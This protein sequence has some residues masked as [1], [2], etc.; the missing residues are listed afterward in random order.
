MID[1]DCLALKHDEFE[2]VL[3]F[4]RKPTTDD[5]YGVQKNLNKEA[6]LR[7][8]HLLM[9][10]LV[11]ADE[12]A[13]GYFGIVKPARRPEPIKFTKPTAEHSRALVAQTTFSARNAIVAVED[14]RVKR[15]NTIADEFFE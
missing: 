5:G 1:D 14:Q 6:F 11:H 8:F 4:D 13:Q 7:L 10:L 2:R 9:T 15:V 12:N 3:I